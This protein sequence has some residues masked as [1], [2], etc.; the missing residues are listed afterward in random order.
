MVLIPEINI[1][2]WIKMKIIINY[3][4]SYFEDLWEDL[5]LC[6]RFYP[7]VYSLAAVMVGKVVLW[8]YEWDFLLLQMLKQRKTSNK[9]VGLTFIHSNQS[10]FVNI[11]LS[12]IKLTWVWWIFA[13]GGVKSMTSSKSCAWIKFGFLRIYRNRFHNTTR[14]YIWAGSNIH[15]S[16]WC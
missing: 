16:S 10:K 7:F 8:T 9:L 1:E 14:W 13:N 2:R 15:I 11:C 12:L 3:Q 5:A 4:I 6:K